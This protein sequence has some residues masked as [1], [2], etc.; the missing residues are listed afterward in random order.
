MSFQ[1]LNPTPVQA[2]DCDGLGQGGRG[3]LNVFVVLNRDTMPHQPFRTLS[4]KPR[5]PACFRVGG[6]VLFALVCGL[7]IWAK[8]QLVASV[9]RMVIADPKPEQLDT[10]QIVHETDTP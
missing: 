4:I 8:L 9:P 5:R 7:L 3:G 10:T 6:V 1:N 2:A